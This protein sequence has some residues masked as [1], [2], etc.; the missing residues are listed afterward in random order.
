LFRVRYFSLRKRIKIFNVY[1]DESYLIRNFRC[2][3]FELGLNIND[4]VSETDAAKDG[5]MDVF[6]TICTRFKNLICLHFN[7]SPNNQQLTLGSTSPIKFSSNLLELHVIVDSINEYLY[8]V[9]GHFDQLHTLYVTI[10]ACRYYVF[11]TENNDVS[12]P[13]ISFLNE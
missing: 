9:D 7:S 4:H 10:S 12:R 5:N 11:S 8:L 13:L 6:I 3:I 1:L 2:Q